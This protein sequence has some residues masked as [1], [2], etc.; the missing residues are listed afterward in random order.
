[1]TPEQF[2]RLTPAEFWWL[3][4]ANRPDPV[5]QGKKFAL[6]GSE[7]DGILKDLKAKGIESKWR[8]RK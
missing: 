4:E 6:R 1:V 7:V 3:W 8:K 5:Y 2:W